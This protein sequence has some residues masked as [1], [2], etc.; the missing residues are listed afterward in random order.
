MD[1]CCLFRSIFFLNHLPLLYQINLRYCCKEK[2][3]ETLWRASGSKDKLDKISKDLKHIRDKS[4]FH[5]DR[6]GTID[7]E[8]VWREAGIK[9]EFLKECLLIS[10]DVLNYIFKLENKND[11]PWKP[12]TYTGDEIPFY[13]RTLKSN[14]YL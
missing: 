5:I 14:G 2:E 1:Y 8:E 12:N 4:H 7:S 3:I 6:K 11:F 13:I 10:Y 9:P